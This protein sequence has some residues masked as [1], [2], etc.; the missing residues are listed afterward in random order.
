MLLIRLAASQSKKTKI[1]TTE[2]RSSLTPLSSRI[3]LHVRI[4]YTSRKMEVC[5]RLTMEIMYFNLYSSGF[6]NCEGVSAKFD[7]AVISMIFDVI[8]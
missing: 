3:T 7:G 6:S 1:V 8:Y 4:E 2:D 5:T